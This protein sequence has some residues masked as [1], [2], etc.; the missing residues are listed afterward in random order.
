MVN[1]DP[2]SFMDE[3]IQ[4]ID[5]ARRNLFGRRRIPRNFWTDGWLNLDANEFNNIDYY[6]N[7]N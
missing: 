1:P 7:N 5:I 6:M 3:L 2:N 4:F